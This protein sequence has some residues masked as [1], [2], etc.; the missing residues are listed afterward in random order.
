MAAGRAKKRTS[1]PPVTVE[2]A[3]LTPFHGDLLEGG[4][5]FEA[6]D[7]RD[8]DFGGQVAPDLRFLGCRI[9]RCRLDGVLMPRARIA[10]SLLAELSAT[11]LALPDSD[12]RES[13]I[14]D[15]RI[16]ALTV[17]GATWKSVRVRGG[18]LNFV[19]LTAARLADVVFEGC[20]IG[21]LDL[22]DARLESV[23]FDACE[24]DELGREGARLTKVDL[25]TTGLRRIRGID[26][27]RGATIG[28]EQLLDL[29]PILAEHLGF[30]VRE[31]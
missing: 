3:A 27:L 9:E 11:T 25:S 23:H 17:S 13:L 12:W 4:A 7:F 22:G 28:R 2:L 30:I 21:E 19:D 26:G 6:I 24:I 20:A 5:D 10:E 14:V 31:E 8:G 1:E 16:G 18:K 29:A 15:A